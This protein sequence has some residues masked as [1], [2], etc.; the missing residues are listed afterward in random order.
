MFRWVYDLMNNSE[1]LVTKHGDGRRGE[2]WEGWEIGSE[3]FDDSSDSGDL[4]DVI[5]SGGKDHIDVSDSDDEDGRDGSAG[6]V[7]WTSSFNTRN[8]KAASKAVEN[9]GGSAARLNEP[10]RSILVWVSRPRQLV[11]VAQT[12]DSTLVSN[13]LIPAHPSFT[14]CGPD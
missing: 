7:N 4:I 12:P 3:S 9:G 10:S 6:D 11:G 13:F 14:V 5:E 1:G 2:A 8:D